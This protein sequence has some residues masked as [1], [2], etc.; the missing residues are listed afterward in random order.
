MPCGAC[1]Q[2]LAELAPEAWVVISSSA[3]VFSLDDLLPHAFRL[4][5]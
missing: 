1:R 4:R 2:W 3:K 5:P